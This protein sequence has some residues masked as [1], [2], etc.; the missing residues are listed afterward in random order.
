[1]DNNKNW[2]ARR[3]FSPNDEWER[4]RVGLTASQSEFLVIIGSLSREV[5][6]M[7]AG[8]SLLKV[9]LLGSDCSLIG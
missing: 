9:R 5:C 3:L 7:C 6:Q 1:M 4:K 8:F 2:T